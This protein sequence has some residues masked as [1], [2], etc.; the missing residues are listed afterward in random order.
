MWERDCAETRRV[1]A[2]GVE[3]SQAEIDRL[4]AR[5]DEARKWEAKEK[6]ASKGRRAGRRAKAK[7]FEKDEHLQ[8]ML[9][10]GKEDDDLQ[11][12]E[13]YG[14]GKMAYQVVKGMKALVKA[15][16]IEKKG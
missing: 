8:N 3:A 5:K 13:S 2:I 7:V 4:L 11:K 16:P 15:L 6:T 9:K 14:W 1:I 10:M 12:K